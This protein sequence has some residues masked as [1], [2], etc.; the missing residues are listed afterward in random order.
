VVEKLLANWLSLCMYDYLQH[1]AAGRAFY[2]LYQAVKRQTE[3]GPID[4]VLGEACYSLSE[5]TLLRESVEAKQLV[6]SH[7]ADMNE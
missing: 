6:G 7:V 4:A 1:Q 3:K 5:Q 2:T